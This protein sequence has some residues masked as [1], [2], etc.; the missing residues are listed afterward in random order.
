[1][2]AATGQGPGGQ[3]PGGPDAPGGPVVG[4][5]GSGAGGVDELRTG[6][7]HPALA[8][9]WQ[10]VVT[11]TPTAASWLQPTGE[12]DALA[13]VTGR[14]VRVSSRLP[15]EVSPHPAVDCYVV[16]PAS[17]NTVAKL[18]L[19]IADNQA[20]TQVCE[21]MGDPAVPVVVFPWVNAAHEAHPAWTWHVATLRAAGVHLVYDDRVRPPQQVDGGSEPPW[22]AVLDAVA[23][24]LAIRP[25]CRTDLR[26]GGDDDR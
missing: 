13:A 5:V 22:P 14:A 25:H 19:G 16:A 9:G 12:L 1:M 6:F 18:A 26:P 3:V 15:G 7:V 2:T 20:C 23:V 10:V 8:R 11:L 21:A 24:A 17:A 4:L